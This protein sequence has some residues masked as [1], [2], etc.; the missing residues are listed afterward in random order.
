VVVVAA[1]V[2]VVAAVVV[3]VAAVV[4]VVVAQSTQDAWA[5]SA[6]AS[7]DVDLY[8]FLTLSVLGPVRVSEGI[9]DAVNGPLTLG[10]VV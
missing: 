5:A 6:K 4:V 1:V 2:V 8:T 9:E 7:P 3:V 10:K